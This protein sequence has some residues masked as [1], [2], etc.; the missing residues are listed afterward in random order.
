MRYNYFDDDD[1]N[2]AR[3]HRFD[4]ILSEI[5]TRLDPRA[6]VLGMKYMVSYAIS[7]ISSGELVKELKE[8]P[9][10]RNMLL[11][12]L[13]FVLFI[14]FVLSTVLGFTHTVNS[15]NKKNLKFN[16]D[17][18]KVCTNI[19]TQYGSVKWEALDSDTYGEDKARLI[20]LCYARQMDFDNDGNSELMVCYNANNKYMLEVYGYIDGKLAPLYSDE[21]NST[22]SAIDGSWVGF[23]RKS[24]KYYIC[25]S[26]KDKPEKVTF[27]RLKGNKFKE[28]G[29]CEYD[30]KN[31][32]YSFDGEINAEDFE[33]IKL[34]VIKRSR[35]EYITDIV[36]NNLEEF[37]SVSLTALDSRKSEQELRNDAFY[38][39]IN[40]RIAQYGEASKKTEDNRYYLDGV[41]YVNLADFDGDENDELVVAYRKNKKIS[42]T[43][44]YTGEPI[45]IEEPTYCIEIYKWNGSIAKKIFSKDS[46]SNYLE[47]SS[48][49]YIMLQKEGKKINICVNRYTYENPQ[50]YTATS[51]IYKLSKEKFSTVFEA[52]KKYNYGYNDYYIDG[53]YKYSYDFEQEGYKVPLFMDDNASVDESKYALIY[54]SGKTE[55]DYDRVLSDTVKTIQQINS[56]YLPNNE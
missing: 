50:V 39:I 15:Q 9:N 13:A 11:K 27:Y 37:S 26:E 16:S 12:L 41:A 49:N 20:G 17:A 22:N 7:K 34:S 29:G 51:R 46:V 36:M 28:Q 48:I 18:G 52:K 23:Y 30:Y 40:K 24:N 56:A 3:Q 33:T 2:E 43:N 19:I 1:E 4:E 35:A 32:I 44:Y 45:I 47:D 10:L 38:E 42:A 25:K 21:A 31:N 6:F 54:L 5:K 8:L 53:K 55:F 14:I